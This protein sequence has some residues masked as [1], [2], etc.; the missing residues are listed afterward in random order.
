MC[1][2]TSQICERAGGDCTTLKLEIRGLGDGYCYVVEL[3]ADNVAN[4]KE[5]IRNNT[6][7]MEL[8]RTGG[9]FRQTNSYVCEYESACVC[10]C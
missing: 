5:N 1:K 10:V 4:K 2:I 8:Q 6:R 3:V 7:M 9:F